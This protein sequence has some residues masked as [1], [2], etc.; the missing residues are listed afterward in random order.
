MS[1]RGLKAAYLSIVNKM[2]A[3]G[4]PL[5][6]VRDPKLGRG[7]VALTLV[8][9]SSIYVQVALVGKWAGWLGGVDPSQAMNWFYGCSAL[10]WARKLSVDGKKTS[11][12][13]SAAPDNSQDSQA[14]K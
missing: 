7:D 5:P 14:P 12:G 3:Q 6:M 1:I 2:N 11:L 8:V 13:E 4:I 10:Y 9:L